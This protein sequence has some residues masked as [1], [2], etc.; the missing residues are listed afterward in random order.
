M[1]AVKASV[2]RCGVVVGLLAAAPCAAAARQPAVQDV[3]AHSVRVRELNPFLLTNRISERVI[4]EVDWVEG[5]EPKE[6]AL[7]GLVHALV[8][9]CPPGKAIDLRVDEAIARSAWEAARQSADGWE[10]LAAAAFDAH[11]ASRRTA[12]RVH[13]LY[14]PE[15]DAWFGPGVSGRHESR[16]GIDTVLIFFEQVR[17]VAQLWI[18]PRKV[19]Q[20]IL[21]HEFGHVLGLV[22]NPEHAQREYPAHCNRKK[23]VMNQPGA[24]AALRNAPAA[25]FT[26]K[27]PH[28]YCKR[29][30][31]D[32][33]WGA[34]YWG[35]RLADD[36]DL[37]AELIEKGR[38]MR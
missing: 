28:D 13:V 2:C 36:P 11:P 19:E 29:C 3:E 8:S 20:S 17:R 31:K 34:R 9:V 12:E 33:A 4:I 38:P 10:G 6:E 7:D 21:I 25:L 32:L 26:G 1:D 37:A 14:L 5:G 22:A 15:G 35:R 16:E 27:I 23:C 18:T 30:R 24:L